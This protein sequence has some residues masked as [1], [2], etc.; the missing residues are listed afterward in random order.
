MHDVSGNP[1]RLLVIALADW[2]NQ[3]QQDV[4]DYLQEENRALREQHRE[5]DGALASGSGGGILR[6]PQGLH[7]DFVEWTCDE[8]RWRSLR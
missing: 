5:L 1:F 7:F 4:I 6:T 3:Q 8:G 2:L